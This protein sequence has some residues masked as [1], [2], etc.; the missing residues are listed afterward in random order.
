MELY[1]KGILTRADTGGLELK[2]G[3]ETMQMLLKKIVYREGI[4]DL[5]AEGVLR[6][7]QKIGRGA[8]QYAMHIKGLESAL[9]MRGR[10]S[11]ESFGQMTNPRGSHLERGRS[12]T[13]APRKREALQ[14]Y[15]AGIGV[16]AEAVDRVLDEPE[17]FNVGRLTKWA[18]D[19]TTVEYSLGLCSRVWLSQL[20]NLAKFVELYRA[21]TGI[22]IEAGELRQAGERVWNLQR[23]FNARE[24]LGRKDDM[25]PRRELVEPLDVGDKHYE[26]L[27]EEYI[28]RALDSY[29]EER[30]WEVVSGVPSARKLTELGLDS[31]A[32]DL[33]KLTA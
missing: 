31:V 29:Y 14:R 28:G 6:A 12:V 19:Y 17:N 24:G 20:F 2:W 3:A 25:P 4:G 27:G 9:G 11:T 30:G 5:L 15:C 10:L 33:K 21:A 16:P 22:E 26:P 23:A 32:S 18:E 13:F 7:S 8:E 1:E